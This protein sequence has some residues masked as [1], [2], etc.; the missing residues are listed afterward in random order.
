MAGSVE[1][2]IAHRDRMVEYDILEPDDNRI[3][4]GKSQ[5]ISENT[6]IIYDGTFIRKGVGGPPDVADFILQF[7]TGV[8]SGL[9]AQWLYERLK[10]KNV[11]SLQIGGDEVEVD[12][13]SIQSKLQDYLD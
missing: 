10:D 7:G 9:V 11:S 6:E 3:S 8:G 5:Q 2:Q 12:E 4:A 13:E 1:I